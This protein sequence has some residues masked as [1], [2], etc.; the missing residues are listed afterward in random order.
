MPTIDELP[1]ANSVSDI[2]ELAVSQ[3]DITRKATRSQ[4][5]AGVQPA[6]AVPQNTLLG[7]LSAGTG[8]PESIIVGANL[9]LGNG[10]I[11]AAPPFVISALP[12]AGSPQAEDL[13]AVS[14]G[15]ENAAE[16]YAT[17]MGGLS[18]LSGIDGSNL[19][20]A[21][22]GGVGVRRIADISGDALSIESFG[23]VGDGV[24]D[25]TA[26]FAIAAQSNKPIRL[27]RR[28]YVVNG[29]LAI[30]VSTT[31]LGVPGGTIV[32][33]AQVTMQQ[34]WITLA[35]PSAYAAGITFNANSLA[36][37][38]S[39]AIQVGSTCLAATFCDCHFI[40]AVGSENGHG[41]EIL[42]GNGAQHE[43][44]N[45]Q[46]NSNALN[47][48]SVSGSGT[49]IVTGC[50]AQSNGQAGLYIAQGTGCYLRNNTCTANNI[51]MSIGSWQIAAATAPGGIM[52]VVEDNFCLN[53]TVWGIAVSGYAASLQRNTAVANGLVGAGGGIVARI[54]VSQCAG[55]RVSGGQV[56]IDARTSWGSLICS[57]HVAATM[58]GCLLGGCANILA[59]SN[60]FVSNQWGIDV[61]AIEPALSSVLTSAISIHTNWVG[62]TLAQGGGI[63]AHDGCLGLSILGNEF[64]GW[65]SATVDQA[66]WLHSDQAIVA[67]NSW[68]NQPKFPIQS[69]N[70]GTLSAL[71]IPDIS[72]NALIT[73]S[74]NPITSLMT[75]HQA[76]TVGQIMFIR[77]TDGGA[78]YTNAQVSISGNG[79]G[80]AAQAIVSNGQLIWIVMTNPGSGYGN[81][82]S[83][84]MVSIVGDG[85]GAAAT[86]YVGL[87]VLEG[88]RIRLSCNCTVQLA[89]NDSSPP[90]QNWTNFAATIPAGGAIE[91]E[92][93]YGAWRATSFPATDYL[94][95]TGDGGAVLQSVSGG[96][97]TLRP[98]AGGSLQL[99]NEAEPSGCSSSV[100]RGAPTGFITASPGS[101]F[102][103]LNGG[104]GN[105][106][107]I[108]QTGTDA[109]G[110][111]AIA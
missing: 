66:L 42:C 47:G 7:R 110:W 36:A 58:T 13:V 22:A 9:T 37:V 102:R 100:G 60:F 78:G 55:N 24:T 33:R 65:G 19:L 1:Q 53:N 62:F 105:T 27:D 25:D 39:P 16:N 41:L 99:A 95:P 97:V 28:I 50:S 2:D 92:G 80:A 15:G 71:I 81:I 29:P 10:T 63:F 75:T 83:D 4:L 106:F 46:F 85:N 45:C 69:V 48:L 32:Q 61:S 59:T 88:R 91:L 44:V 67:Q 77:V 3:T 20:A 104:A 6:L 31:W 23:A 76:D 11:N 109:N 73:N 82:G 94:L 84:A 90:Q 5:L 26:A 64:N 43:V 14:Q 103:N 52:C 51:G 40:N 57:N 8:A 12:G 54:G 93:T 101:D 38:D 17:F 79:N 89:I 68:N 98:G 35:G 74:V 49:V 30:A 107:W 87:P 56:G 96:D 111:I 86:A 21:P 72:D 70:F 34:P 108:K 18:D